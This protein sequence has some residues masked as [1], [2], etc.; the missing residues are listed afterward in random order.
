M[1]QK[2]LLWLGGFS[3]SPKKKNWDGPVATGV[4]FRR[5]QPQRRH[6]KKRKGLTFALMPGRER[7]A[8]S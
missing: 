7:N 6:H 1:H 5:R 3:P 2:G 8:R 4:L